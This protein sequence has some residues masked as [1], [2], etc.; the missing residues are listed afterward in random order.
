MGRRIDQLAKRKE[1]KGW[2][3]GRVGNLRLAA[4]VM[5]KGHK[6]RFDGKWIFP[7]K[8]LSSSESRRYMSRLQGKSL[9][10]CG[11]N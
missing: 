7:L 10:V 6:V 11:S 5:M 2:G 1:K 4:V 8:R 3:E 9:L